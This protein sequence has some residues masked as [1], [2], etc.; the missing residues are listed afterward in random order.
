MSCSTFVRWVCNHCGDQEETS[1]R[2]KP[3][4]GITYVGGEYESPTGTRCLPDVWI[5]RECASFFAEYCGVSEDL[6]E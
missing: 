2:G 1:T 6:Q 3:K 5:C 4:R